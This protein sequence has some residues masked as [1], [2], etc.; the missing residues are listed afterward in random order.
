[1]PENQILIG[2]GP[3][4]ASNDHFNITVKGKGGHGS[5]PDKS[6]DASL[7]A[8]YIIQEL[9]SI[10]SRN[11]APL[12]KATF[13]VTE[14]KAGEGADN[15]I[16]DK[17]YLKGSIKS[18]SIDERSIF[19]KRIDEIIK[20]VCLSLNASYELNFEEISPVLVNEK[21]QVDSFIK[22][23]EENLNEIQ[24]GKIDSSL[25]TSQIANL[26]K[27]IP[28]MVFFLKSENLVNKEKE[29]ILVCLRIFV[30]VIV[31]YLGKK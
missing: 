30:T 3:V 29:N 25:N 5:A 20:N 17:A 2:A 1:M 8:A 24:L 26:L 16:T 7:I 12:D 22:I 15:I 11:K 10:I 28:G 19:F 9:Q 31:N 21:Q 13:S 6:I 23:I 27:E 14:F 4:M 18:L